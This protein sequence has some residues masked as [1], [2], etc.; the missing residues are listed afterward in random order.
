MRREAGF[1]EQEWP[2]DQHEHNFVYE[3]GQPNSVVG[4]SFGWKVC[5]QCEGRL[6]V[7][8]F[9]EP[10]GGEHGAIWEKQPEAL[11]MQTCSGYEAPRHN[12]R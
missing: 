9:I 1:L 8:A 3:E 12:N 4:G 6:L 5:T 10:H 2:D 11:N 7:R